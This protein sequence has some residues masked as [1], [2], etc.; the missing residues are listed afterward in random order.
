MTEHTAEAI[1]DAAC[2]KFRC[3]NRLFR[4][5]YKNNDELCLVYS[6]GTVVDKLPD[7]SETFTLQGYRNFIDPKKRFDR[8]RLFLC[9][10]G[11]IQFTQF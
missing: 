9:E 4:K 8:L 5:K 3:V 1:K 2:E 7:K 10:K 11:N 6:D